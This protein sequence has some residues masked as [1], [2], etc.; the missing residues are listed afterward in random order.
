MI[1]YFLLTL[2]ITSGV[3][4]SEPDTDDGP[5]VTLPNLGILQGTSTVSAFSG[6]TISQFLSVKY[7]E[8]TSGVHRFK[9]SCSNRTNCI[10][11]KTKYSHFL[12][13]TES[14]PLGRDP[15][16]G[17]IRTSLS[18]VEMDCAVFDTTICARC[19]RLFDAICAHS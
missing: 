1:I 5:L 9:V 10:L 17:P 16:R 4:G 6:R 14:D 11:N 12:A 15:E 2:A 3:I 19:G 8:T 18:A 13:A 7:A